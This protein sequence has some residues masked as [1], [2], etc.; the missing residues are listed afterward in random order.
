MGN[1]WRR[2]VRSSASRFDDTRLT[3]I[4]KHRRMDGLEYLSATQVH[5]NAAREA[6]IEA[7]HGAH[8]VDAFKLVGAVFFED[9]RVLHSV[10]VGAGSTEHIARVC[11]P[12]RGR[13]G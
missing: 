8:N 1:F 4:S 9:R 5:V 12:R 3:M 10:L 11:V 7:A 6:R 2:T 13:V